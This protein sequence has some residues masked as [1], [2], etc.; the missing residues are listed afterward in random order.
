[1]S[2]E[3][4]EANQD[5]M[6]ECELERFINPPDPYRSIADAAEH[7]G[8]GMAWFGFWICMGMVIGVFR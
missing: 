7:I 4:R 8:S 6:D 2:P 3:F 5:V 1:M